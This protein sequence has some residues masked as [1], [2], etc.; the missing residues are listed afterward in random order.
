MEYLKQMV[1]DL[2]SD[3]EMPAVPFIIGE[4]CTAEG[5]VNQSLHETFNSTLKNRAEAEIANCAV[6]SAEQSNY[7]EDAIH[8]DASGQ[9][10]LGVRCAQEA[11][12]LIT[13]EY[14]PICYIYELQSMEK[15]YGDT[16]RIFISASAVNMTGQMAECYLATYTES[17]AHEKS[18]LGISRVSLPYK[19]SLGKSE[20]I[21]ENVEC[22]GSEA[23]LLC[24]NE[25]L[26]P[27][28][29]AVVISNTDADWLY[30]RYFCE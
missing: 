29:K 5:V 2:R 21:L 8:M 6:F 14:A 1:S 15:M 23:K 27:L 30:R 10:L 16:P 12:K 17:S 4:L 22:P 7:I 18:L 11:E 13:G 19:D 25:H 26:S 28:S 20:I 24:W 3:L 9:R